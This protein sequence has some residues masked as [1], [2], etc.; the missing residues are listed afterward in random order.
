MALVYAF[1][2]LFPLTATA[3]PWQFG[4]PIIV[5]GGSDD[6][7]FHHLGA[8]GRSGIAVSDD[9]VAIVWEDNR[10]GRPACYATLLDPGTGQAWT[11]Y[12]ISGDADAYEPA[13]IG[14]GSRRFAV[15][16]EEGGHVWLRVLGTGGLGEAVRIDRDGGAQ[17]A[18]AWHDEHG[19]VVA[20]SSA[21]RRIWT[22]DI[23]LN[24]R[25]RILRR[26][27]VEPGALPGSQAYPSAV[28][29]RDGGLLVAWEDRRR[30]HNAIFVSLRDDA[31]GSSKPVQI[32]ESF[33]GGRKLGYGRGT[34][35]MRVLLAADGDEVVAVWADKRNFRSGY[36][37]F[38]AFADRDTGRFGAN[39]KVQDAFADGA[40][41]WHPVIAAATETVV[42]AWDDDRDGTGDVWL[43]W[44]TDSGWS[45]DLEVPGAAGAG[46]QSEPALALDRNGGLHLAWLHRGGT[47][48][49]GSSIRYLYARRNE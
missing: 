26:S 20:W 25:P 16:W 38:A 40:A 46:D 3:A 23:H 12:R 34:G 21:E 44:L 24:P 22:A 18:L 9:V 36:D 19:L 39:Q 10:S 30:G 4:Q 31:T 45:D 42:V 6:G 14:V 8:G 49:G 27:P 28:L 1:L 35:A 47:G 33:W 32:N 41:Q 13:A 37:V 43:S 17:A 11:E 48:G 15:A 7:V 29:L 2:L 5:S